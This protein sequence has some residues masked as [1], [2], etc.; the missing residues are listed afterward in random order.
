MRTGL[1]R[2]FLTGSGH[3]L[4]YS[5]LSLRLSTHRTPPEPKSRGHSNYPRNIRDP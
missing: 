2:F 3:R 1:N 4:D 5:L